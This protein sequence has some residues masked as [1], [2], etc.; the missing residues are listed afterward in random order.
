TLVWNFAPWQR[1]AFFGAHAAGGM[2]WD[3]LHVGMVGNEIGVRYLALSHMAIEAAYL[4]HRVDRFRVDDLES[5]PGGVIDRGLEIGTWFRFEPHRRLLLEPHLVG[6]IFE[7][8]ND[9]QG[10]TGLGL[11]VSISPVDDQA[12]V[13]GLEVLRVIRARPRVG[14]DP[15]TWN[16]LGEVAWRAQL[17]ER[18]GIQ[19]GARVSTHLLVGEVPMLELKRSMIDEPMAL[20][21]LGMF[22]SI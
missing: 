13:L 20:G 3:N 11:R 19:I 18:F 10:V 8:Y 12:L 14:V 4:T 6:R 15:V 1:V 17:T 2:W 21:S 9:A 16:V 7:V 5:N 22:F